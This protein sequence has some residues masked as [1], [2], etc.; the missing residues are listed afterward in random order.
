MHVVPDAIKKA[1]NTIIT[2]HT[3]PEVLH[4][5]S[6]RARREKVQQHNDLDTVV[7]RSTTQLSNLQSLR[8]PSALAN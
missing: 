3:F 7:C 5:Q 2:V 4:P 8:A 6:C 1:D